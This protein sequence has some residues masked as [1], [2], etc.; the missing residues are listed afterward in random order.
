MQCDSQEFELDLNSLVEVIETN[1]K[2]RDLLP[3]MSEQAVLHGLSEA[4]EYLRC[5]QEDTS[6]VLSTPACLVISLLHQYIVRYFCKHLMQLMTPESVISNRRKI[7]SSYIENYLLHQSHF[8]LKD[9]LVKYYSLSEMY[10][11]I[12]V[13]CLYYNK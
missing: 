6:S 1:E 11:L 4:F 13:V 2:L 3:G 8:G 9:L 5:A 12:I 10:V 7:P